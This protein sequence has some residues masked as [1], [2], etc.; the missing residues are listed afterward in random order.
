MAYK[1]KSL[2]V[3][4]NGKRIYRWGEEVT[5]TN[6]P[7]GNFPN[8]IKEG[9]IEE[10]EPAP[11]VDPVSDEDPNKIT[12]IEETGALAHMLSGHNPEAGDSV[13]K[14]P[15]H[16]VEDTQAKS[17][18]V[19]NVPRGTPGDSDA[20]AEDDEAEEYE[21]DD[22]TA[23]DPTAILPFDKIGVRKLRK[24]LIARGISFDKTATKEQLYTLYSAKN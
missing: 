5:E 2:S 12:G 10:F 8:L 18:E 23:N 1:V 21:D 20:T 9:F 3:L 19:E 6:F 22:E 4:G 11:V 16:P 17:D 14:D 15:V 13:E 24:A 7:P